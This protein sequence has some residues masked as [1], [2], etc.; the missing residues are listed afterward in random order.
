MRTAFTL[1]IYRLKRVFS[2]PKTRMSRGLKMN[3]IIPTETRGSAEHI[4]Y[5]KWVISIHYPNYGVDVIIAFFKELKLVGKF[6]KRATT[7]WKTLSD[8]ALQAHVHSR[9]RL[10]HVDNFKIILS[11]QKQL[12]LKKNNKC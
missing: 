11:L 12:N 4:P 8:H 2:G 10:L 9:L 3:S 7:N 5:L 1:S 6:F